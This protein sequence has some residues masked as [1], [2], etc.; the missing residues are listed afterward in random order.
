M[1]RAASKQQQAEAILADPRWRALVAR[2]ASADGHFYYAVITTGVYCLPSCAARRARPENV[3][4]FDTREQAESAGFRPC[5]RCR[6]DREAPAHLPAII[7]ACRHMERAEIPPTLNQLAEQAGLSPHHFHRVFK[8][9]LGVTPKA[10]ASAIRARQL[11]EGLQRDGRI[12]D[13]IFDAG[14]NSSG[15]F[16]TQ[17]RALLGMEPARFRDGGNGERIE[18]AVGQ[19]SL[20]ALL[21]ARSGQGICAI[22]LGDDA[23]ALLRECQ[24]HFPKAELQPGNGEFEALVARVAALMDHPEQ[25][26]DLP[27]DIRGTAFQQK[28]WQALRQIP[29]GETLSYA[30]LAKRIGSPKAVRAVAGACANN[31]LAVVIPCHR[32]VRSDGDVSGYRWGVERKRALLERESCS[33]E[34]RS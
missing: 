15:R 16:Y 34:G 31:P 5:A 9:I 21:V 8:R 1:N 18:V 33:Q 7:A 13:A 30:E 11:R 3:R 23:D 6:P 24:D 29:A 17:A 4:F 14:Y 20:G 32:V 10:Y 27:L 22:A 25:S 12:T 28:V 26:L 19:C 2:D